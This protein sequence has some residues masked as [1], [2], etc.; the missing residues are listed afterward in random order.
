MNRRAP[1]AVFLATLLVTG[2]VRAEQPSPDTDTGIDARVDTSLPEVLDGD[3]A[4]VSDDATDTAEAADSGDTAEA[5]DTADTFVEA[6]D[7][8]DAF[9][10]AL[11]SGAPRDTA[12]TMVADIGEPARPPTITENSGD[13]HLRNPERDGCT[14]TAPKTASEAGAYAAMLALAVAALRRKHR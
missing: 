5:A 8:A 7:T 13:P 9:E 12:D 2:A 14:C 6:A 3:D 1:L 10:T 11:D 4:A